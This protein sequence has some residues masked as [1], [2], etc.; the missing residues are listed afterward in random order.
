MSAWLIGSVTT[1]GY[2]MADD[3][4]SRLAAVG[5]HTRLLMSIGF[6][7]FT[8]GVLIFSFE[9][10][11]ALPGPAWIAATTTAV[12]TFGVAA[13]PLDHSA[14]V[15][16]L[17]GVAATI[18]YAGLSATSLL[19]AR[20]LKRLGHANAATVSQVAGSA[21][22]L[23]LAATL[24]GPANGLFQRIGTGIGDAWIMMASLAMLGVRR[25]RS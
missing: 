12:A 4:I 19:A 20:P 23:C 14:T 7:V 17:H 2:S 13:L 10:R 21:T 16:M 18:G 15:D 5:A 9:L 6:V 8:L 1:D 22:A 24:F 3:A 11:T 25:R